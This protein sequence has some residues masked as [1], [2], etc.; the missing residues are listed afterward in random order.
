[1]ATQ[2]R[3]LTLCIPIDVYIN[4]PPPID[5]IAGVVDDTSRTPPTLS[6]TSPMPIQCHLLDI[7]TNN[8]NAVAAIA[9]TDCA[10]VV[11]AA[12]VADAIAV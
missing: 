8:P 11:A 6:T 3:E 5:T 2:R 12:D 4:K 1:M 7:V 9:I 10:P